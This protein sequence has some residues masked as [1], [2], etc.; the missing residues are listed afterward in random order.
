[1][2]AVRRIR[3]HW[4]YT[5]ITIRG[6]SHYGRPE[7][8]AWCEA[9]G[10][11]YILGLAEKPPLKATIQEAADAVRT[12]RAEKNATAIRGFAETMYAAKSWTV[13]RREPRRGHASRSVHPLRGDQKQLYA[14][15]YC[16]RGQA[17]NLIKL[18][19][20]N[21]K[22]TAPPAARPEIIAG[23]IH[24]AQSALKLTA[25]AKCPCVARGNLSA[26]DVWSCTNVSGLCAERLQ[27]S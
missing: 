22:A 4:P 26:G 5:A 23:L 20:P 27:C 13:E 18:T 12:E 21:S 8:M 14:E 25:P 1:M 11:D 6:D 17:E 19:K 15:L 7:V 16:A 2:C 24:L 9:N 10:V 3:M